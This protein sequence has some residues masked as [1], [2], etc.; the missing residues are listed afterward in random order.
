MSRLHKSYYLIISSMFVASLGGGFSP[1]SAATAPVQPPQT[2]SSPL[3][4]TTA[5]IDRLFKLGVEQVERNENDAALTSLQQAL[6]MYQATGNRMGQMDA[7]RYVG[8]A[9]HQLKNH[10]KA[11]AQF[12]KSLAIAQD[13]QNR[14]GEAKALN[15]FGAVYEALKEP[16]KA[17]ANYEKARTIAVETKDR[18]IQSIILAN[19]ARL[20][21]SANNFQKEI[22]VLNQNLALYRDL[23][24]PT[25]LV[26]SL[27]RSLA[28]AQQ[29]AKNYP[30]AITY[31]EA[32]LTASRQQQDFKQEAL[33]LKTIGDLYRLQDITKENS[34]KALKYYNESLKIAEKKGNSSDISHA[35]HG[36]AIVYEQDNQFKLAVEHFHKALKGWRQLNNKA[37]EANALLLL[38]N[39]YATASGNDG[40][41][42]CPQGLGYLERSLELLR[43]LKDQGSQTI[44][45]GLLGTCYQA[46]QQPDRAVE[47][48]NQSLAIA[49]QNRDPLQ[50]GIML[51]NLGRSYQAKGDLAPAQTVAEKG[52][53]IIR[54]MKNPRWEVF[55]LEHLSSI[56]VARSADQ[57]AIDAQTQKIILSQKYNVRLVERGFNAVLVNIEHAKTF[58]AAQQQRQQ[59]DWYR[60]ALIKQGFAVDQIGVSTANITDFTFYL[61]D[62]LISLGDAY[63]K[64]GND[65]KALTFYQAALAPDYEK[66]YSYG[67]IDIDLLG[68]LG[69]TLAR[70]GRFSEAEKMMRLALKYGEEFRT[71]LGYGTGASA[72]KWSDADRIFLAERKVKNFRQLQQVLVRQNRPNEAL[73][74]LRG[75]A[76]PHLR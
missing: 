8:W 28:S 7:M 63:V 46:M 68:K 26:T 56:Y 58:N 59:Y 49:Q 15:G 70:L 9:Q 60:Q 6:T 16:D 22:E 34:G 44:A 32:Y 10:P 57:K 71:G 43:E 53:S 11:L 39:M 27:L 40:E 47:Y 72:K 30:E 45:V 23:K 4:P 17:L 74:T 20:Y 64:A 50:E 61:R 3:N 48:L 73:E 67:F 54:T 62:A 12:Q 5:E 69:E 38:G 66:G 29:K 37:M 35:I 25:D 42:W 33:I 52:L 18:K 41:T 76:C 31:Y 19:M 21:R 2:T 36:M 14:A 24:Q 75:S 51:V 65:A 55:A 1:I 13:T